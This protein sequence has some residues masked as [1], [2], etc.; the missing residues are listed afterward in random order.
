MHIECPKDKKFMIPLGWTTTLNGSDGSVRE[1]VT[2][3]YINITPV[4]EDN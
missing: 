3:R 4:G 2:S 1:M